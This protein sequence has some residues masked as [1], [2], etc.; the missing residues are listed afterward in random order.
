MS[1]SWT[2]WM[3][4]EQIEPFKDKIIEMEYEDMTTFHYKEWSIPHSYCELKVSELQDHLANGNTY[5]WGAIEN[6]ELVAYWWC[7]S[8]PFIDRKRFHIRSA[9]TVESARG[10]GLGK[11]ACQ[12][13]IQ[14][15][16]ELGC[17]DIATH[18]VVENES[19]A[20]LMDY[21]GFKKTRVEVIKTLS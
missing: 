15:A 13:V 18:Y 2:G 20:A 21:M 4:W 7:Y 16:S 6:N 12:E 10:K 14:K 3:T 19:M 8:A 17:D 5:F 11:L 1:S 9:M